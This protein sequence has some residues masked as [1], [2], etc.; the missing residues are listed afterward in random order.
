MGRFPVVVVLAESEPHVV[1]RCRRRHVYA[2][3]NRARQRHFVR[4]DRVYAP[5]VVAKWNVYRLQ[6]NNRRETLSRI[7]RRRARSWRLP[8][9]VMNFILIFAGIA[10]LAGGVYLLKTLARLSREGKSWVKKGF[11]GDVAVFVVL[12]VFCAG[13][14]LIGYGLGLGA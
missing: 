4:L 5:T 3:A 8:M 11:M 13:I 7:D 9:D 14:V 6:W 10:I 2:S 12:G 1:R